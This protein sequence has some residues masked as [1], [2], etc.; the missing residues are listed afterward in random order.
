MA[1]NDQAS[2]SACHARTANLNT[3]EARILMENNILVSLAWH[4]PH[5]WHVSTGGY[6]VAPIPPE[7]P[8]LNELI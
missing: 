6:I 1:H 2:G 3:D 5:G 8:A 7:G 4:L